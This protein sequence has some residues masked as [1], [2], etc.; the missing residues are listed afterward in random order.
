VVAAADSCIKHGTAKAAQW[1]ISFIR[2]SSHWNSSIFVNLWIFMLTLRLKPHLHE[3]WTEL[4]V[5]TFLSALGLDA[6]DFEGTVAKGLLLKTGY[7]TTDRSRYD[8]LDALSARFRVFGASNCVNQPADPTEGRSIHAALCNIAFVSTKVLIVLELVAGERAT[9][10]S[11]GMGEEQFPLWVGKVR[12]MDSV[13]PAEG[14]LE[15]G[16]EL[17]EGPALER[18]LRQ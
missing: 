7:Y 3:T 18:G 9:S 2:S 4:I 6:K 1:L 5:S 8:F 11:G 17:T 14:A 12:R 15:R 16:L 10:R 13:L